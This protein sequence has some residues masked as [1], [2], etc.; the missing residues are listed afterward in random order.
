MITKSFTFRLLLLLAFVMSVLQA[1]AQTSRTVNQL[2]LGKQTITVAS[3][4]VITFYDFKGE[5]DIPSANSSNSQSLTVFAPAVAGQSIQITFEQIDIIPDM[6]SGSY[7]AFMKVYNGT[8]DDSGFTWATATSQVTKTSTLPDGNVL[9]TRGGTVNSE[10]YTSTTPETYVSQSADGSMAV[11]FIYVYAKK[12]KGW[13]ATVKAVT[14]DDMTVTGA[15][16]D[17]N[18]IN[19]TLKTKQNVPLANAYVTATGV[20]NPDNVTGIYFNMTKNEG[21][22]DATTF[23]L[24]KGT[25]A[26]DATATAEG[27][28]YKFTLNEV[29]AEGTT[30]FT[31]KGDILATAE[32]GTKAQV[33]ITKITSTTHTDGITP[34]T[35]AT[36]VEVVNPAIALMTSTPQTITVGEI[37]LAFFDE[38]GA[39]GGIVSKTNGQITFLSGTEGKKV[40]IDF[41]KNE[42]WHGTYYNQELRIYNGREVNAANLIKTLQQGETGI[43][44]STADDGSMTVVLYSDASNE[45]AANGWE[46][47]VSL[48]TPQAMDFN[49]Q[50]T[51]TAASTAT[52]CAGDTEQD[53]LS[54]NVKAQNTEPAMQLTK[55]AFSAGE[56]FALVTKASLYK[57]ADKVGET[58]VSAADFII[59]LADAAALNEGDNL[60][61]LKYD[62]SSEALNNQKVSAQLTSVTAMVN[63]TEKTETATGAAAER[64]VDN[65]ILNYKGQGTVT[66]IVNGSIAF[67]SKPQ[68]EYSSN[69]EGGSDTR[70]NIFI[71]KHEGS[72]CQID[73]SAFDVYYASSTY[74][75]KAK[76]IVYAGQG[77]SGEKLWELTSNADQKVGP[78]TILRSTAADGALTVVFSPN[79][80]SSYYLTTGWKA[81]VSEYKLKD[82]AINTVEVTQATTADASIGA[83]GQDLLIINVKTEGALN[84]ITLS[85]IK[86]N[87]KGTEDNMT[88][89]SLWHNEA[90]VA[91][92]TAAAEVTLALVEPL[93]LNEGNNNFTVK[94]DVS[95]SAA[96]NSTIDARLVSINTG[97][98]ISVDNGDPEGART[99]KNQVV[100]T[101]G[102]HGIMRLDLGQTIAIY[103]DGGPE[104]NG[105][106]VES[107][108]VTFAPTGNA[109]CIR[110]TGQSFSINYAATI[111]IYKGTE[112]NDEKKLA[113]ISGTNAKFQPIISDAAEDGGMLT[114][115]Y[116][117]TGSSAVNFQMTAEGYK[118]SDVVVSALSAEDISVSEVLKGQTDV[119]ML[120]VAVEAKGE[121]TPLN[122]TA[123]DITAT[124]DA[125]QTQHIYATGTTPSFSTNNE[126]NGNY[127]IEQ[128]GTYYFWVTCDIKTDASV[129]QT[130]AMRLNGITA[131]IHTIASPTE[132]PTA[133]VT[134]TSGKSGVYTVGASGAQYITIQQ[135]VDD[136][137]AL[138]MEGPVTLQI[139]AG[140]YNE[141][142]RIPYI[143]GMGA[144]NTL[145]LESQSGQRDV[146]IYHNSYSA[147]GYSDDQHK[148]DYGVVTL[149]E[150]SYVTL[151]HLDI[152]TTDKAYKAVVM[153]KDQSRHVTIDDCYLHAPVC[154]ASSGEDVCLVGHTIIDEENKNND[155]LTIKNCLLEG[156]KMG[157]SM[158]G[159]SYVALPKEIGGVIEGN[160]FLNNGQK[161]IYVMDE[162][163]VKI[164]NNVITIESTATNKISVGIL[165]MQLRDD[166]D[167]ST[168]ITGN[169]FNVAPKTYCAV[170]NFRQMQGTATA[171]VIIANNVVSLTSPNASTNPI[172]FTNATT[173]NV[174]VANNT[175]RMKGNSG[176]AAFWLSARLNDE[177]QNINIVNNIFQNETNGAAISIYDDTNAAKLNFANNLVY[178]AGT[179]FYLPNSQ[180]YDYF[181]TTTGAT[182]TVNK[183]A[184]FLSDNVLEPANDLDG[185]LL[186]AQA[187]SYVTTDINGNSRPATGGTIGAYEY[188]ANDAALIMNEGF[189]VATLTTDSTAVVNI[190]ANGNGKAYI[191]ILPAEEDGPDAETIVMGANSVDLLTG[192]T[193]EY[194]ATGLQKDQS[195][196]AYVVLE[197]LRGTLSRVYASTPFTA[198][199]APVDP[200]PETLTVQAN[201]TTTPLAQPTTLSATINGGRAPYAVTWRDSKRNIIG[202]ETLDTLPTAPVTI[203]VTPTECTDY[204]VTVTDARNVSTA[205]TLR[206]ITTGEAV[207]A[208]FENLYLNTESY[209]NARRE[210]RK[211]NHTSFVNGSYRF[212][213]DNTYNGTTWAGFG[214]ANRTDNAYTA[215]S[216]QWNSAPG[217]AYD[218]SDNYAVFYY[219]ASGAKTIDVLNNTEGDSIRGFYIANNAYAYA[220]MTKGDSFA[221]KFAQG[222]WFKLTVTADNGNEAEFYLADFRSDNAA[223]HYVLDSW[224]W[225][226]LSSLGKVKTLTFSMSSSDVGEYGINTPTY[227]CMDNFN[228]PTPWRDAPTQTSATLTTTADIAALTTL[229]HAGATT[230]Y[231]IVGTLPQGITATIDANGMATVTAGTDQEFTL[232]VMATQR[233]CTDMMRI[234][235]ILGNTA[236]DEEVTISN[237]GLADDGYYYATL[238]Y[239]AKALVVPEGIT[240]Y[241]YRVDDGHLN[242]S[243]TYL[244]GE[245]IPA[246]QGVVLQAAEAGSYTFAK[247]TLAGTGD[248]FSMLQGSDDTYL[249][250]E[251]GYTYFIL[252]RPQQQPAQGTGVGFWWQVDKGTSV[253]NNPHKAYLKVPASQ[254]SGLKGFTFDGGTTGITTVN[255]NDKENVNDGEWYTIDGQRIDR[256]R[257]GV[258]IIKM[259]DGTTRKVIIK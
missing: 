22:F 9:V 47:T 247:S 39:E 183:L 54:I 199:S 20:M 257:H 218:G 215:L 64:T 127:T 223:N 63:N 84:P 3:D 25:T 49:G 128:T 149:Y 113:S 48:F 44:R 146:K 138:G 73:F 192:K 90:K 14:L 187:L 249:D 148:K 200:E 251:Q 140:N 242:V 104:G 229:N 137:A 107:A 51:A 175:F 37:P 116:T 151:R 172:K 21:M 189:P 174:N 210:D 99:L 35:A 106:K 75:T 15:G 67:E 27:A 234:P 72:V 197:S 165:D 155:Y 135:A 256:P 76:F 169:I 150:A 110:L 219:Y 184:S 207:T 112:V 164:R 237:G 69:Y 43:V 123:F 91:E 82:M 58:E 1:S 253:T 79:T 83:A 232:Y 57:G 173:R 254:A 161:A 212:H 59:T 78:G 142:V 80:S 103:D 159:T 141:K 95:S 255:G 228:A 196:V 56:N 6:T 24:F 153:V 217:G 133:N 168:E 86:L 230:T 18:G 171:P 176:G 68:S 180:N 114:I 29:L 208:T 220:S 147:G 131:G 152:S 105:G 117:Y 5:E 203:S 139:K 179:T 121:L 118:K 100:M 124:G 71:P 246:A 88:D 227:F 201:S 156:G 209:W 194:L 19:T 81:T 40:M 250:D 55:M 248:A 154:T 190:N 214:Y 129:G 115:S 122:I 16:S 236:T 134:V 46:A 259:S 130:A 204:T 225:L 216:H 92:A 252:S 258:N 181:L 101:N 50:P 96:E 28:G 62:I 157:V 98:D 97:S 70:T 195:Y 167:E 17:Y 238:Y 241:T 235:F 240:A 41:T 87:M 221:K 125:I 45:I 109:D 239:A 178:T 11:G 120:Q 162:L 185:D 132:T 10:A 23:K 38:G 26:V 30:T 198:T 205:D 243:H 182:G 32:I 34:F 206:V 102:N 13:K 193:S 224:Q 145:T 94:A 231:T 188:K 245:T 177:A 93:Q 12:C 166:Y 126:F 77:T 226:D 244:A 119:K 61:T 60:F 170:M 233:G 158:G 111:N 74:G 108:V 136:I 65:V 66:K 163:G 31:I 8:P 7:P 222:D 213:I 211:D 42:I 36:A 191:I 144:V 202:T 186:T 33:D 160:T 2:Q 53:M 52:V 143:K 89:F 85:S 4:E